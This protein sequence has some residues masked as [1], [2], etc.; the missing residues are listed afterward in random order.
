[1]LGY[2]AA[3]ATPGVETV[4]AKHGGQYVR[5]VQLQGCHGHLSLSP[6]AHGVRVAISA[7]LAPVRE[8]LAARLSR[9]L[10][11]DVDPAAIAMHLGGDPALASLLVRRPGLRVPGSFDGFELALR[12]VL[13][14]QVT[15]RGATTLAGRLAALVGEPM[16]ATPSVAGAYCS[17]LTVLAVPADRLADAG[18][19]AVAGIGL[20][21][22]R[23]VCIVALARAVA[24]GELPEL[25]G[26]V[27]VDRADFRRRLTAL[28]GIG[29]WTAEYVTMRALRW[30]DA[31]P[32]TDLVL[33]KATGGL[34]PARLRA[35]AERWRPWRAYA[36]QH[37]WAAAGDPVRIAG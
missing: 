6:A 34:S 33:R 13:G 2:L 23:A 15:V 35:A 27:C 24:G 20:P 12:T 10:D 9:L 36:A 30:P 22:T 19:D 28:P 37:L 4:T 31:F 21:H 25:T 26:D 32:D 5:T 17:S 7:G 14:Q 11:L 18:I 29:A 1:M 3:R 8:S 16:P